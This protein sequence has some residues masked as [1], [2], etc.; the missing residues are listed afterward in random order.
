MTTTMLF[1][2][3]QHASSFGVFSDVLLP[4]SLLFLV[5][6]WGCRLN[7]ATAD[8]ADGREDRAALLVYGV[9]LIVVSGAA[10]VYVAVRM[11]IVRPGPGRPA[12]EVSV[13][14]RRSLARANPLK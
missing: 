5:V 11:T 10:C 6:L 4:V 14:V 12:A 1:V 7:A 2:Q 3:E 8:A 9:G 13:I